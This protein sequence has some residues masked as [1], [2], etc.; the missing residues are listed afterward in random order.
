MR[1]VEGGGRN[2]AGDGAPQIEEAQNAESDAERDMIE[3]NNSQGE[4]QHPGAGSL[5]Q[6][7]TKQPSSAAAGV[8]QHAQQ[9]VGA[10]L[11]TPSPWMATLE[12]PTRVKK[13]ASQDPS[14]TPQWQTITETD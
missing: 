8:M 2:K 5:S 6:S 10:T 3:E 4:D 12:Y 11:P 14:E 7:A 9:L 1:R 13:K